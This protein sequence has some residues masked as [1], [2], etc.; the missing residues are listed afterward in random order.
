MKKTTSH[1]C[2]K[3]AMGV[4][5]ECG[6]TT[7]VDLKKILLLSLPSSKRCLFSTRDVITKKHSINDFERQVIDTYY[8]KTGIKLR[9]PHEE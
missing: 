9:L 7:W 6:A 8:G 2:L 3:E 1:V 4:A 5:Y